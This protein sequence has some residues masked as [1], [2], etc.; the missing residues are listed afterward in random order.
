MS[1]A[2]SGMY[3]ASWASEGKIGSWNGN[4]QIFGSEGCLELTEDEK[5]LLFRK[6]DVDENMLGR[7]I[8]GEEIPVKRLEHTELQFTLENFKNALIHGHACETDITDNVKSFAG[9]IASKESIRSRKPVAIR[10]M[11]L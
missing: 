10:S 3:F 5:I 9:V 1:G 8:P 11:G 4:I 6:H 7:H 2:I